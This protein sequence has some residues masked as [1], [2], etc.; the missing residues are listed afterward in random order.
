MA[1]AC[2]DAC[3]DSDAGSDLMS[4]PQNCAPIMTS[5]LLEI[6]PHAEKS[7]NYG[8]RSSSSQSTVK[9]SS[10]SQVQLSNAHWHNLLSTCTGCTDLSVCT[11]CIGLYLQWHL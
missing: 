1:I 8:R 4:D 9:M 7:R 10:W 2:T 5:L 6:Q 11:S 3:S